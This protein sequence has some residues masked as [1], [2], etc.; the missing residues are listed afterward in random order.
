MEA[1]KIKSTQEQI[2]SQ[3][4]LDRS[5]E[6]LKAQEVKFGLK[7]FIGVSAVLEDYVIHGWSKEL[8]TRVAALDKWLK[9]NKTK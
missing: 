5:L 3:S 9:E 7:E 8:N 4:Q 2:V 1:V 6:F